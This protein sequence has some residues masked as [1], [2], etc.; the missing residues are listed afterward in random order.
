MGHVA[1]WLP[2]WAGDVTVHRNCSQPACPLHALLSRCPQLQL[3]ARRSPALHARRR[4]AAARRTAA[5]NQGVAARCRAAARSEGV[6]ARCRAAARICRRSARC[7]L[8]RKE[9]LRCSVLAECAARCSPE[10]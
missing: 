8:Q 6:A 10:E 9:P 3:A 5:R 2:A 7:S 4:G 1:C